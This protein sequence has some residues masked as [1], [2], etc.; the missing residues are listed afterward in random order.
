VHARN[1]LWLRMQAHAD[2]A[3]GPVGALSQALAA[4][5]AAGTVGDSEEPDTGTLSQ[6]LVSLLHTWRSSAQGQA[7][8]HDSKACGSLHAEVWH[9]SME[10]CL[11]LLL[12]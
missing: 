12:S 3:E 7:F 4:A 8:G 9:V 1:L 6:P 2:E 5:T 10:Q 11:P